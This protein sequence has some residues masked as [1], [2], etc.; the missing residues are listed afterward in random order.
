MRK[1]KKKLIIVLS[2]VMSVILVIAVVFGIYVGTYYHA[3]EKMIESYTQ[4]SSVRTETKSNG[5]IVCHAQNVRAGFIFYAG[6]KVEH[7]AYEPLMNALA[8]RGIT[9]VLPKIIFNLAIFDINAGKGITQQY[10]NI[11]RWYV[12][13][14]SLGGSMAS[15]F[16]AKRT[17]EFEGL[18]LLASYS[19]QNLASSGLKV[20]SLYGDKDSVLNKESYDK[21]KN[22]LPLDYVE[23]IIDGGNHAGFGMYGNQKGDGIA[24][25]SASEQIDITANVIAKFILG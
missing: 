22:N 20:L 24:T 17:S 2:I 7:K 11:D 19:T 21:N 8:Q 5:D 13:G 25:I 14:H 6:G 3:D 18:V 15:K 9:C 4:D 10:D 12:G 1:T 16:V 23:R